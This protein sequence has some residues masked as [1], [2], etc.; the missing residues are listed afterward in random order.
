MRN[1]IHLIYG[2]MLCILIGISAI[3]LSAYLPFGSVAIAILIG[4]IVGNSVNIKEQFQRGISFSEKHILSLAIALMGV[5]LDY[6]ILKE[7]GYESILLIIV[8]MGVT[9]FSS[10]FLAR[11]MKWNRSLAL[12]LGIGNGICGSSAIAAT[13][14]IIEAHEED[15]GLSIAT[16]NFLG[17]IGIFLLPFLGTIVLK[18]PNTETGILIGNTLQAVG[19]VTAGGFS[20]SE[21]TGQ[22]A[23]I[24]KMGRILMLTPIIL[25]L[26]VVFSNKKPDNKP[27]NK[28]DNKTDKKGMKTP[29]VPLFIIAFILFSFIPTFRILP[30]THIQI[31]EKISYYALL[32]AMAAVGLK[33]TIV[34]ILRDGKSALL[35][36]SVNFLIQILFSCSVIYFLF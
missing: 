36:G 9:I 5:K 31:L 28:T 21:L 34:S 10:V 7:L 11:V 6:A 2:V 1:S 27:D 18:L 17:T 30:E 20:I 16:V 3:A 19:H 8:A 13:E 23:T 14:Q 33:I 24:I 29:K 15:V 4:I 22:T 12:L 25:I 32:I 26:L 35:I